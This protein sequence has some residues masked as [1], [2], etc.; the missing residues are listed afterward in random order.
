MGFAAV[1]RVLDVKVV[2]VGLDLLDGDSPGLRR[3]DAAGEE[4]GGRPHQTTRSFQDQ[5]LQS[6]WAWFCCTTWLP[7]DT[8]SGALHFHRLHLALS[9]AAFRITRLN[10]QDLLPQAIVR[11]NQ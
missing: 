4:V 6:G 7:V 11:F 1:V 8:G 5:T 2:A 9:V 3:F 10:L